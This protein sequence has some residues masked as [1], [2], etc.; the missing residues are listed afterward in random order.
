MFLK[1]FLAILIAT[2]SADSSGAKTKFQNDKKIP[3]KQFK[4]GY[5][6]MEMIT[7]KELS[8]GR[9]ILRSIHLAEE[10]V[11]MMPKTA[12]YNDEKVCY[13]YVG[14]FDRLG[15][16]FSHFVGFPASPEQVGTKFLLFSW[17][18][19]DK[20]VY[21]HYAANE[22]QEASRLF[23]IRK[24][25]IVVVHGFHGDAKLPWVVAMRDAFLGAKNANI[26]LVDWS[27][28]STFPYYMAASAN[29]ALVGRQISVLLQQL[30]SLHPYS[31]NAKRI[32]LVGFSLG[33]HVVGF[34]G[35][36]FYN[37]TATKIGRITALDAAAPLFQGYAQQVSKDDAAYVDAIHTTAG[38]NVLAGQLGVD[39]PFGDVNFY[40]NGGRSQ[41]GCG[42]F[43]LFCHHRRAVQYFIE[44]V[45]GKRRCLFRSHPCNSID[46]FLGSKCNI[47]GFDGEMGYYSTSA[48]GRG[49]QYLW[50]NGHNPFCKA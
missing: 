19:K 34:C 29:A 23:D 49:Q 2:S 17:R 7:K 31:L 32:H 8:Q 10:A 4:S 33:A 42:F 11:K 46:A 16:K 47:T 38:T 20:P 48:A 9:Q 12:L 24:D 44:S 26:I 45:Q 43:D 14:C 37:A 15:G 22:T 21:L 30:I 6:D 25:L 41:P 39:L 1:L 50:T 35:R 3:R 13:D 40:P 36:H 28:G 18:N 5:S 27:A